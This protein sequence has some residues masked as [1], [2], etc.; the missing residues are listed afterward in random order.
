[1]ISYSQNRTYPGR[2]IL[3]GLGHAGTYAVAAYF[4]MG[5][6][7]NSRNRIFERTEDGIRTVPY[8]ASKVEDPALI[9]YRP[10]RRYEN[11][12]ILT[13][14]DQTDTIISFL[15]EKKTFQD[16]L[17]TRTYEPDAPHYTSRISG[18]I[19]TGATPS[20]TFSIL[21]KA[22][23]SGACERDFFTYTDFRPGEA[24]IIHTYADD[25]EPLPPYRGEPKFVLLPQGDIDDCALEI[26]DSLDEKNRISLYLCFLRLDNM[27]MEERVINR[28]Q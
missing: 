10:V 3:M 7:A 9:L 15:Q 24:R 8:D 2:G 1:M 22:A 19:E 23:A 25:V 14:G 17:N 21:R 26:W 11:K 28:Y 16:A 27:K 18:M 20:W 5:R 6:S 12:L 13:N 4:I